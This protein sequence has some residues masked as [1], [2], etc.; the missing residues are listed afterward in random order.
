MEWTI[1]KQIRKKTRSIIDHRLF[2]SGTVLEVRCWPQSPMVE[3]DLHLPGAGMHRWA[4]VPYIK[5]SVEGFTFRDYTPFGWDAQTS[6]CSLLIDAAHAGPGS[7]WAR[8]LRTGDT[9]QYLKTDSSG[10]R[11][12]PT[13][14]IVGLGDNSSLA[15]LLA[16]Q[17]LTLP[18]IRFQGA[19]ATDSLKTRSLLNDYFNAPLI[20]HIG[21][22]ELTDWL[23]VQGYCA[24]HTS[25]YLSGNQQLIVRLR[26][27]LQ[28]LGHGNIFV[29]SF[30]C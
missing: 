24:K 30:W 5:I 6:T 27:A 26:K 21:E 15:H 28:M 7:K 17:Q 1:F 23:S 22:C 4:Q 10:H 29:K 16:L 20:S 18:A 14:M 9:V 13:N 3:I 2:N 8:N 19:V 12:H 25:F 11:P